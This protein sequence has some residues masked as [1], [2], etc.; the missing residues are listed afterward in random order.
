M[1]Q[2]L[3]LRCLLDSADYTPEHDDT[4]PAPGWPTPGLT[5][6]V[7]DLDTCRTVQEA[8]D[9]MRMDYMDCNR[10]D[11]EGYTA[12]IRG[13]YISKLYAHQ[14]DTRTRLYEELDSCCNYLIFLYMPIDQDEYIKEIWGICAGAR[15]SS[16]MVSSSNP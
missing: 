13:Y 8:L 6:R 5:C 1:G 11:T 9:G 12:A 3:K 15:F 14:S 7:V 2:G 4:M 16:L 10:P